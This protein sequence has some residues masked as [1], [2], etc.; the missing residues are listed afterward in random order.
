MRI[1]KYSFFSRSTLTIL[2]WFLGPRPTRKKC[3][4]LWEIWVQ[5]TALQKLQWTKLTNRATKICAYLAVL[6]YLPGPLTARGHQTTQVSYSLI[7]MCACV[8]NSFSHVW[9]FVTLWTVGSSVHGNLQARIL[10]WVAMHS[11]RGSSRPSYWTLHCRQTLYHLSHQ[12]SL[13]N[14]FPLFYFPRRFYY[15]NYQLLY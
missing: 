1:L 12:G 8:L 6:S 14:F 11:P 2:N 4:L 13:N 7:P 3:N 15:I 5:P 9:L 10:K